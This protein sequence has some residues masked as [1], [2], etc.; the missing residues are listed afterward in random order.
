[1]VAMTLL[2]VF[3]SLILIFFILFVL[4]CISLFIWAV[5]GTLRTG[6]KPRNSVK[7]GDLW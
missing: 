1:M 6:E 2:D 5:I 7:D 3:L 4:G